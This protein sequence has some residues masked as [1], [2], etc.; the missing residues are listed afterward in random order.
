MMQALMPL[1]D[2]GKAWIEARSETMQ[3]KLLT[4]FHQCSSPLESRVRRHRDGI[5]D[6]EVELDSPSGCVK[7]LEDRPHGKT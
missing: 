6:L 5:H 3:T 2:D 7:A 1:T 4:A